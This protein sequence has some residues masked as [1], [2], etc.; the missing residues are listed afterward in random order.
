MGR[1]MDYFYKELIYNHD[2]N[3]HTVTENKNTDTKQ[4]NAVEV[5]GEKLY[6]QIHEELRQAQ[7]SLNDWKVFTD[8]MVRRSFGTDIV[9]KSVI[10]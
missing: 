5:D 10:F 8:S 1:I 4:R 7:D 9:S 3:L 6:E 2:D